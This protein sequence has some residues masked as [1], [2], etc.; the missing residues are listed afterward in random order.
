[1]WLLASC[2]PMMSPSVA[3]AGLRINEVMVCN[4]L[5]LQDDDG[6]WSD[7]IELH[8]D[9]STETP[10]LGLS[11]TDDLESPQRW[12]LPNTTL[13]PGAHA[14]IFASG[15][16]R[17]DLQLPWHS[18]FK[19]AARETL[20]LCRGDE[21]LEQ[22]RLSHAPS[23]ISQ[24]KD[25]SGKAIGLLAT[26]TPGFANIT[27]I[28]TQLAAPT[29]GTPHGVFTTTQRLTL[30]SLNPGS[31]SILYTIDGSEPLPGNAQI[32][33]QPLILKRSTVV[34]ARCWHEGQLPSQSV[35][36]TYLFP[37]DLLAATGKAPEGWP[38]NRY[39]NRQKMVYGMEAATN[40]KSSREE[41]RQGFYQLPTLSVVTD[42]GHLLDHKAGI[43]VNA[44]KRGRDW[45]R[46]ASF[47]LIDPTGQEAGFQINAGLRIRGGASRRGQAPKHS[48]RLHFRPQYGQDLLDYP[49]FG[50]RGVQR[51]SSIDLRTSQNHSWASRG[52]NENTL[53]RDVFVRDTQRDLNQ[54]HTRTRS[55]HLCINA[56]Y[57]GI[58]QTQE[59][60]GANFAQNTLGGRQAD[61][62][63]V[64]V[65]RRG[66][67]DTLIEAGDGDL[68]AWTH[69][70]EASNR[71]AATS[72]HE[73]RL[74]LYH[75]LQGCD[76]N[77]ERDPE[78]AAYV[79]VQ[80][81]I[82]YML[83]ILFTGN[84]DAPISN[85]M[86][87]RLINNWFALRPRSGMHGFQFFAHDSEH[88]LG[89]PLGNKVNRTGPW[90]AGAVLESSNPQWLHQQL[91]SVA[92]YRETFAD[93]AHEL[94]SDGGALSQQACLTRLQQRVDELAP[95]ISLHAARWGA[96]RRSP[97]RNKHDWLGA[98]ERV[99]EFL[100]QRQTVF[101]PQL[102]QNMR[103]ALGD[104]S[105]NLQ[106]APL[107]SLVEPPM[108]WR[109][110]ANP[111]ASSTFIITTAEGVVY[112]TRNGSD[113]KET[114][115]HWQV[116]SPARRKMIRQLNSDMSQRV[117]V[118]NAKGN[119]DWRQCDFDDSAWDQAG[120][121]YITLRH[122]RALYNDDLGAASLSNA[123]GLYSR[124]RFQLGRLSRLLK[125]AV[126]LRFEDGF[127]ATI[128]GHEI[129]SQQPDTAIH[130]GSHDTPTQS[131]ILDLW[132]HRQFLKQGSNVLAIH[133]L[134]RKP[135]PRP[136]YLSAEIRTE[137]A[138]GGAPVKVDDAAFL[139]AR[140]LAD[141]IWSAMTILTLGKQARRAT[142]GSL[143]ISELM[144]HPAPLTLHERKLGVKDAK[145]FEF[146][147]FHNVSDHTI[148]LAKVRFIDGIKFQFSDRRTYIPAGGHIVLAKNP[149][150]FPLRYG[151]KLKVLGPYTGSL[152]NSGERLTILDGTSKQ[153][154]HFAYNDKSP[155]PTS[156]DGL[157]FSLVLLDPGS[158]R[159]PNKASSWRASADLHGS[160][161]MPEPVPNIPPMVINELVTNSN[162]PVANAIELHN[163][164]DS[165]V[166]IGGW[167]LTDNTN[168]PKKWR[169][170]NET[171]IPA[172]G[173][174][175]ALEDND[176]N[177][178]N[179]ANLTKDFFGSAFSLSS[180]GEQVHLFSADAAG[181]LTGYTHGCKFGALPSELSHSRSVNSAGKEVYALH[182][183]SLGSANG[184]PILGSVL[185]TEV[186]YHPVETDEEELNEFVEIWNRS[187]QE[188]ALY[189]PEHPENRWELQGMDY[190]FPPDQLLAAGEY[191]LI[192]KRAPESFRK[193]HQLDTEIQVFG[194][195]EGSLNNSGERLTLA[196]PEPPI[197]DGDKLVIPMVPVDSLRYNDKLPWPTEPDGAG[198]TLERKS[199]LG[200]SDEPK[201]WRASNTL[202][203][204]PGRP[205]N[206]L[207]N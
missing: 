117:L 73:E 129:A 16:D 65:L 23:D 149:R 40:I 11:L 134:R 39:I 6:A 84:A 127:M 184:T 21:I 9:G 19:L 191:A 110:F 206:T 187:N 178:V 203:G 151:R 69:L 38:N 31:V 12:L 160:P 115:D 112:L 85:F 142:A 79:D 20:A 66:L 130:P 145:D 7:W 166:E 104:V 68:E 150:A 156:A 157:G 42:L 28:T 95:A 167:F 177:P 90:Q 108:I 144:Y 139:K 155:W 94:L 197:I 153:I 114:A 192:C 196:R 189:D 118:P 158:K 100:M 137:I 83:I 123:F 99:K 64:K 77:G 105:Q 88:S 33:Q 32:Y 109:T 25:L 147:E 116:P 82:D 96:A 51:F 89:L 49:L 24:G 63:I 14:V 135:S 180:L 86:E 120:G 170:P 80:N 8:N 175:V 111:R 152:K 103:Y 168:D 119:S 78:M 182:N 4:T 146:I 136:F 43:Y 133:A 128:N 3:K 171:I 179:N 176:S 81:L 57:W 132:P 26:P 98:V 67:H 126:E 29:F 102:Q 46:P 165:P 124:Q 17:Q 44:M 92:A 58:Y 59:H 154:M 205:T 60:V 53:L 185:I 202:G 27:E 76:T 172:H 121:G 75:R 93:R 56:V 164:S 143:V 35:T 87:N 47:E 148:S 5:T 54:P 107:Y 2:L 198:Y 71:L 52:S 199:T 15:K 131:V 30:S 183:P 36:Q 163:P 201:H 91:Q 207:P 48:F 10:L 188:V 45:E 204:S 34:R 194:P 106:M 22:W 72:D 141:G 101:V 70:W 181:T 140:S 55:Y 61:Y 174:W 200:R 50:K 1:M 18:N 122:D 195:F 169:I 161:G 62:D 190:T 159:N 13:M 173:Y 97:A 37:K 41:L 125:A 113:P 162:G 74:E 193:R 186:H 138:E